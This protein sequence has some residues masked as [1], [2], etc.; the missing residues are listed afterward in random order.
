[1]LE[2]GRILFDRRFFRECPRQHEFRLENGAGGFDPAVERRSHPV[3]GWVADMPLNVD[4]L[5]TAV[6][7]KPVPIQVSVAEPSCTS[8]LADKSSGSVSPRFCRQSRSKAASSSAPMIIRASDP[9]IKER[10]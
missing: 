4:H 5:M 10:R 8:R 1:M 9:P 7:L 6:G 3:Q 2:L